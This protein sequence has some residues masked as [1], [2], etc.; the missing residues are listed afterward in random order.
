MSILLPEV[1]KGLND[2]LG[3]NFCTTTRL[4]PK[5]LFTDYYKN[6]YRTMYANKV[7]LMPECHKDTAYGARYYPHGLWID[8]VT[9]PK[10]GLEVMPI[11]GFVSGSLSTQVI[12]EPMNAYSPY[13]DNMV[14]C[15]KPEDYDKIKAI[16]SETHS[17]VNLI[18][19]LLPICTLYHARVAEFIETKPYKR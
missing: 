7:D 14:L 2:C 1:I 3:Q 15:V 11:R 13:E 9:I 6:V 17:Y 19:I 16:E 4:P 8:Y 12:R 5:P 10:G 18:K